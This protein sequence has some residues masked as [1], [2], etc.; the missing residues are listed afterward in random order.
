MVL[1]LSA[2]STMAPAED[3]VD[4][5][6][7]HRVLTVPVELSLAS[8]STEAHPSVT[9][10]ISSNFKLHSEES[11]VWNRKNKSLYCVMLA[12]PCLECGLGFWV[13]QF[14]GIC[15]NQVISERH[16]ADDVRT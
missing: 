8:G 11:R 7:Q 14:K 4:P 13:P 1:T 15:T 6:H 12:L 5:G 16:N 3:T 10:N 2:K 9:Q